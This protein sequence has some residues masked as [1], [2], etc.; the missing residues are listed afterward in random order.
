M[1]RA[2]FVTHRFRRNL[3]PPSRV[4]LF[5]AEQEQ[6]HLVPTLA[7]LDL[8]GDD[9]IRQGTGTRS[10][11]FRHSFVRPSVAGPPIEMVLIRRRWGPASQNRGLAGCNRSKQNWV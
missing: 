11:A 5:N 1:Q 2:P 7:K 9:T 6:C 10:V 8:P 3:P 4:S